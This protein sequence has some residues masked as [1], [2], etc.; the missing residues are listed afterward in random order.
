M[1][2]WHFGGGAGGGIVS[3]VDLESSCP[4]NEFAAGSEAE[5]GREAGFMN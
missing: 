4:H 5:G 3:T 2:T 1:A